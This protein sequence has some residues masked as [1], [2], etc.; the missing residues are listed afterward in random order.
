WIRIFVGPEPD[1]VHDAVHD[2]VAM[3]LRDFHRTDEEVPRNRVDRL[4]ALDSAI[5]CI[6]VPSKSET[7][8][9]KPLQNRVAVAI[10]FLGRPAVLKSSARFFFQI[11]RHPSRDA[12]FTCIALIAV[13]GVRRAC[14]WGIS[15]DI[16]E[17][18]ASPAIAASRNAKCP[19]SRWSLPFR[20][21]C[22]GLYTIFPY[23][24]YDFPRRS[25]NRSGSLPSWS[26]TACSAAFLARYGMMNASPLS[27]RTTS[28]SSSFTAAPS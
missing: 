8:D 7:C 26:G 18:S 1:G 28:G 9:Q 22:P 21:Y 2:I 23:V 15:S 19:R 13:P 16:L 10:H 17:S 27:V 3:A 20:R 14:S 11:T 25:T 12:V 6:L 5:T 24:K 4:V